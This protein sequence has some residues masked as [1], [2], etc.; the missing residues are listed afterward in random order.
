[1]SGIIHC[2]PLIIEN[3][4]NTIIIKQV[5]FRTLLNPLIGSRLTTIDNDL[6][7]KWLNLLS[8][9]GNKLTIHKKQH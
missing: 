4:G 3:K 7:L 8:I 2:F 5:S 6:H 9:C 1:M